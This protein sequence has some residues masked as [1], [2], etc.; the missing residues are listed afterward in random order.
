L[1][2]GDAGNTEASRPSKRQGIE[3]AAYYNYSDQL[4]FDLEYAYTDAEFDDSNVL[5][6]EIPGAMEDI[7]QLGVT[8]RFD[9][10]WFSTVRLRYLG[11]RPLVE[12][13]SERSDSSTVVNFMVGKKWNAWAMNLQVL[14]LFD[15]NDHDIDYFYASRLPGESATGVEDLHYHVMEPRTVRFELSYEF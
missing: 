7:L 11:E 12:D 2:V 15:S 13:N 14:N 9:D 5:E 3:L 10:N 6:Q 4:S 8:K 1:F